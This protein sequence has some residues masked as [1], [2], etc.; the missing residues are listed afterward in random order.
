M[1]E[2]IVQRSDMKGDMHGEVVKLANELWHDVR[3]PRKVAEEMKKY[4]DTKHQRAWHCIVGRD[5]NSYISYETG[6]FMDFMIGDYNFILYK[7]GR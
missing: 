2:L 7:N 3:V 1:S 4:M 6:T 5:F